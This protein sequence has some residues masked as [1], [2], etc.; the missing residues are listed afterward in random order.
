MGN[1]TANP[2]NIPPSVVHAARRDQRYFREIASP[3]VRQIYEA[4]DEVLDPME[5]E[6]SLLFD[7]YPD[8]GE[9]SRLTDLVLSRG[10]KQ[11]KRPVQDSCAGFGNSDIGKEAAD[12]GNVNPDTGDR[13]P[14]MKIRTSD[15]RNE[16]VGTEVGCSDTGTETAGA[17]RELAAAGFEYPALP[18]ELAKALLCEE[19][20]RRRFRHHMH[21]KQTGDY[22]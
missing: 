13:I 1:R 18:R 6:G 3:E 19:M 16:I 5:Y 22:G 9:I 14:D 20:C 7:E 10:R 21:Q 4:V 8:A 2:A 15:V 12:T 17:K 11:G